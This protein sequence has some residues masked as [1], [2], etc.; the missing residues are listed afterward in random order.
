MFQTKHKVSVMA[1]L[2]HNTALPDLETVRVILLINV[3][4]LASSQDLEVIRKRN[5]YL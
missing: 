4:H 2:R 5:K 1:E 3:A